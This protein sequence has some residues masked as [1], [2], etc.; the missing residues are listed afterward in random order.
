MKTSVQFLLGVASFLAMALGMPAHALTPQPGS[1][2]DN[3]THPRL[4]ITQATL[5]ALR[6]AINTSY[7]SEYRE[8]I[9]DVLAEGDAD[10]SNIL[11]S[12]GHD[13]LRATMVHQA[14]IGLV[15][16]IPSGTTNLTPNDFSQMAITKLLQRLQNNQGEKTDFVAALTYDWTFNAMTPAQR[17]Q[18][19]NEMFKTT[20]KIAHDKHEGPGQGDSLLSPFTTPNPAEMFSSAYFESAYA[21][22]IAL[23]FWGD[24]FYD[25]A[26][27]NAADTFSTV[28]RNYGYLDAEN[29]VAGQDGGWAEWIGYSS[30]HPR[31]HL[32]LVDGWRTATGE[33]VTANPQGST[34]GNA[35]RYFPQLATYM[36]DPHKYY[37]SYHTFIRMGPGQTT[38]ASLTHNE[39]ARQLQFL[40]RPLSDAGLSNESRLI[41]RFLDTYGVPFGNYP[42]DMLFGF[43]GAARS[44][45]TLSPESAGFP[46]SRWFKNMGAFVA[47]TGFSSASDSVF[48][49]A[50]AHLR[51]NGQRGIHEMPG[52]SLAK[53][54]ELVGTRN[55]AHRGYGNLEDY[56]GAHKSNVV[57]FQGVNS[58]LESPFRSDVISPSNLS[59]AASGQGTYDMGG[60]E[61]VTRRNGAFYHVRVNRSRQFQNGIAHSREY[62]W[63]PGTN[64]TDDSDYLVIYDRTF[65]SSRPEWVYH[66]PWKPT[67]SISGTNL[68][69]GRIGTAYSGSNIIL[70]ELNSVGDLTDVSVGDSGPFLD[71]AGGGSV[72]GTYNPSTG[73]CSQ[74]SPGPGAL[75]GV[76]FAKTLLPT[77][78]QVEVTRVAVP[79]ADVLGRQK[80]L[81]VKSHRWQVSVF[82]TATGNDHRFLHVFE[83]AD[84]NRKSSMVPTALVSGNTVHEGVLIAAQGNQSHYV[85]LFAHEHPV[86][87][88][89]TSTLYFEKSNSGTQDYTLTPVGGGAPF[90]T[91]RVTATGT[92]RHIVTGLLPNKTYEINDGFS[93]TSQATETDV[94]LWDY[95]G[96]VSPPPP[97]PD[98]KP[99]APPRNLQVK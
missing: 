32:L 68:S 45:S 9:L 79:D 86:S 11:G 2:L 8:Y 54:G 97:P 72:G 58:N 62:V 77:S 18:V 60:I 3:R 12:T 71:C 6:N 96:S 78:A 40:S 76:A 92:V 81:A 74:G 41:R 17:Q 46:E 95:Q 7:Q 94:A 56:T 57:Y 70:K 55:V 48:T 90:I 84:A 37:N 36:V 42:H 98:P 49:V 83:T 66:V 69:G 24:G 38:D 91:Y 4:H 65:A 89:E 15:G 27:N 47:R 35:M 30:W 21:F 61:Q 75:H 26:A 31:T 44:V 64:P 20:R 39:M 23:A 51:F 25:T 88:A 28:M 59:A 80:D 22:Y 29:F 1:P 14:F 85:V 63:L 13:I 67:A 87:S 50:D 33:N 34:N 73:Y 5:P 82:P 99:P 43:L 10:S 53:F 52:F 93:T 19:A 16:N